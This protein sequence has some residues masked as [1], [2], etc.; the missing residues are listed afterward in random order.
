[1]N[2]G[3]PCEPQLYDSSCFHNTSLCLEN[4]SIARRSCLIRLLNILA[5]MLLFNDRIWR[6]DYSY[7]PMTGEQDISNLQEL[8][9]ISVISLSSSY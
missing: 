9:I 5:A 8:P 7:R 3:K 1:M 4:T 6:I 2:C